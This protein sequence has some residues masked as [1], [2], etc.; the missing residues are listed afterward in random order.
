RF[1]VLGLVTVVLLGAGT[2]TLAARR[3]NSPSAAA[4]P[5]ETRA[6]TGVRV[7]VQVLNSTKTR[8]LARRATIL[9]RDKGYDVVDM[10]TSTAQRD[11]T[12]VLD[13]SGHPE[14]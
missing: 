4:K 3:S 9:L 6:P 10:G 14:W 12:V 2:V 11:S 13:L 7:R 1:I 5:D 8:G